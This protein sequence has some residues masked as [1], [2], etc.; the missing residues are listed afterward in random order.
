MAQALRSPNLIQPWSAFV[1]GASLMVHAACACPPSR[2]PAASKPPTLLEEVDAR[3]KQADTVFLAEI[4]QVLAT[5]ASKP[6]HMQAT[7]QPLEVFKGSPDGVLAFEFDTQFMPCGHI[8]PQTKGKHVVY[9]IQKIERHSG[10][11]HLLTID[12][13]AKD[14]ALLA[15][16]RALQT[17]ASGIPRP[18]VAQ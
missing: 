6:S 5:A 9:F 1:L 13:A 2:T 7:L 17:E 4:S 16:L 18:L 3:F 14:T 8:Q 10:G 11:F 15:R 12:L